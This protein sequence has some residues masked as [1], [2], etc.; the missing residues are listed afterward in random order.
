[1]NMPTAVAIV[2]LAFV[3]VVCVLGSV[4]IWRIT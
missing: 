4:L 1:M 3:A 2:G